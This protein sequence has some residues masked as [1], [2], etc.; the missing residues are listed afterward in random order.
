MRQYAGVAPSAEVPHQ[1]LLGHRTNPHG[2]VW[3]FLGHRLGRRRWDAG[4]SWGMC[5]LGGTQFS[6]RCLR[7]TSC[8][9]AT[10]CL[11]RRH[12]RVAGAIR[13]CA[14][15]RWLRNDI[16]AIAL[17]QFSAGRN[18]HRN[19]DAN[20]GRHTYTSDR[21]RLCRARAIPRL[22]GQPGWQA[23]IGESICCQGKLMLTAYATQRTRE[24]A[25]HDSSNA[26]ANT[27]SIQRATSAKS[28]SDTKL[29]GQNEPESGWRMRLLSLPSRE[30]ARLGS[31]WPSP[32]VFAFSPA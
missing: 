8:D 22:S 11:P 18:R 30:P 21:S 19:R 5:V 15:K 14:V 25:P 28:R 16:V 6:D 32:D 2:F 1:P 29:A 12:G 23:L 27:Q 24:D 4:H 13:C 26:R 20:Q 9:C 10:G 7:N 3:G 31:A 17:V